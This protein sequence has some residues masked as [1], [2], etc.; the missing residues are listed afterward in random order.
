[1]SNVSSR[2]DIW[3]K[4]NIT[5]VLEP[6]RAE[7]QAWRQHQLQNGCTRNPVVQ[8][9]QPQQWTVAELVPELIDEFNRVVYFCICERK[10]GSESLLNSAN[11]PAHTHLPAGS[12]TWL[13]WKI[14]RDELGMFCLDTFKLDDAVFFIQSRI[15][16]LNVCSVYGSDEKCS[17]DG[18][19]EESQRN[20]VGLSPPHLLLICWLFV[21]SY[22]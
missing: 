2:S 22:I 13:W 6:P 21:V 15:S 4:T 17:A 16:H 19:R 20:Q 11:S 10:R 9:K 12:K 18:N 8:S 7:K 5:T 3:Q 14:Q 1:M